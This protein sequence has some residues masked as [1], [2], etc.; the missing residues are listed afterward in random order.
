MAV[1]DYLEEA[2]SIF[3]RIYPDNKITEVDY[4]GPT[5]VVYTK[6][7]DLFSK[8]D[9]IARAIAQELRRRIAIRPDP[10]IMSS[11]EEATEEIKRIIPSSSGTSQAYRCLI[12]LFR[13]RPSECVSPLCRLPDNQRIQGNASV[14]H[15][16]S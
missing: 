15:T 16:M 12:M 10:S 4:E 7:Q 11:E 9:D 14:N 6:D 2:K 8:R 1:R 5:I 13:L 3:N